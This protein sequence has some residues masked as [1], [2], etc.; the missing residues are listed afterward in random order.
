MYQT[1]Q[2]NTL[3]AALAGAVVGFLGWVLARNLRLRRRPALLFAWTIAAAVTG[4]IV[5]LPASSF[6]ESSAAVR[7]VQPSFAS[8]I[9]QRKVRISGVT[10]PPDADV[11]VAVRSESDTRWWLNVVGPEPTARLPNGDWTI[12]VPIGT[13]T[14]GA[15][16]NYHIVALSRARSWRH[17]LDNQKPMENPTTDLPDWSRSQP[18]TIRRLS[19]EGR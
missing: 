19:P 5:Y 10:S 2:A 18:I 17:W 4:A 15:D 13:A 11:V 7:I 16:Q 1:A 8:T 6:V 12:E 9:D 3:P 14:E